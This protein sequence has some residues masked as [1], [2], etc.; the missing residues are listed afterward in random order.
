MKL[1]HIMLA[2]GIALLSACNPTQ[3]T[4]PK[5]EVE[6][7]TKI[8]SV[9]YSIG[10]TVASNIKQNKD[11]TESL[12]ARIAAEAL[13]QALDTS[14]TQKISEEQAGKIMNAFFEELTAKKIEGAKAEGAAYLEKNKNKTGVVTLPSGL[15]YEVL[16]EGTGDKPLPTDQVSVHYHGTFID[17]KVFDSSVERGQPAVFGVTQ[18]IS[19]WVE[20]LQLMPAGSKWKL[21]IPYNLAYGERGNRGIPPYSTLIFEVELLEIVKPD[22]PPAQ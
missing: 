8:D 22:T 3:P 2:G 20:A 10:V 9:S 19:G 4:S 15:Q 13:V 18:V 14:I 16:K 12:D 17:G 11:L 1:H 21:T 7:K 5:K 6:L